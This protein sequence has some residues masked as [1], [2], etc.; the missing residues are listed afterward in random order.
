MMNPAYMNKKHVLSIL[1]IL[2]LLGCGSPSKRAPEDLIVADSVATNVVTET[3]TSAPASAPTP[4]PAAQQL[5]PVGSLVTPTPFPA[6]M[7]DTS[8]QVETFEVF[9]QTVEENYI[10]RDFNGID[11]AGI[12]PQYGARVDA[13]MLNPEF[14]TMLSDLVILLNDEHSYFV[15]ADEVTGVR[16]L[17]Q[18]D[19]GYAG[20]GVSLLGQPALGSALV[21]WV[22]PSNGAARAGLRNGDRILTV[23][24]F[25]ICCDGQGMPFDFLLGPEGSVV[26]VRV[27]SP[28]QEIREI[29]VVR[30]PIQ[31]RETVIG[32]RLPGNIGYIQINLILGSAGEHALPR[33]LGCAQW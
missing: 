13:G 28:A 25:P 33:N 24:G 10:Y 22:I 32:Q 6:V 2:A 17:L 31:V 14:W 3:A 21:A 8:K 26:T 9:W 11:W 30:N 19:E 7:T 23:D 27:Q 15:P 12:K 20:I 18:G 29:Q 4:Q 5:N 16:N 1:L